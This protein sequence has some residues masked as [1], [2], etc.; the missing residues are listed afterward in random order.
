MKAL[1]PNTTRILALSVLVL[2]MTACASKPT[3]KAKSEQYCDLKTTTVVVKNQHGIL[4]EQTVEILKCN[5]NEIDRLFLAQSGMAA[6]CGEFTYWM[7]IG[8]RDV[9]RK[10]VSCQKLDGNWEIVNTGRN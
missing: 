9:R 2:A 4:E 6:N 10:G 8:D 3:V 7:R 1:Y 5:D